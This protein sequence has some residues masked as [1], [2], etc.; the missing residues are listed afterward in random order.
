MSNRSQHSTAGLVTQLWDGQ[1]STYVSIP[2][3]GRIVFCSPKHLD[4]LCIPHSP[5]FSG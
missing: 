1:L 5:L 2:G 3:M 4:L